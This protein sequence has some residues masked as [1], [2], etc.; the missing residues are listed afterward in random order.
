MAEIYCEERRILS[1]A[2]DEAEVRST[3]L[4]SSSQHLTNTVE[5]INNTLVYQK[6]IYVYTCTSY[7]CY[8]HA[9]TVHPHFVGGVWVSTG[10]SSEF[11]GF[12]EVYAIDP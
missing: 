9:Q 6:D 10:I 12:C 5:T 8:T 11:A 7:A 2:R 3:R 1:A 4:N